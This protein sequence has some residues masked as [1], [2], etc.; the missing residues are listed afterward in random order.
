LRLPAQLAKTGA[1]RITLWV[2]ENVAKSLSKQRRAHWR[3]KEQWQDSLDGFFAILAQHDC[4][5][6][7][8]AESAGNLSATLQSPLP[9]DLLE[10]RLGVPPHSVG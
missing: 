3:W 10:L 5:P 2:T 9:A 4:D 7:S 6:L 1:G 8:F